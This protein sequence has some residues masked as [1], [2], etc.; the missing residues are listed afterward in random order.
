MI[1]AT[2]DLYAVL[3]DKDSA[4]YKILSED[5]LYFRPLSCYINEDSN[6]D[7]LLHRLFEE[8]TQISSEYVKFIHLEP[9]I[10]DKK[11]TISYYALVP[12]NI[13]PTNC[14]LIPIAET[15]YDSSMLRKIL[16]MV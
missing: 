11:L 1:K 14:H 12:Y 2:L 16:N 6:I 3:Y 8:H 5:P 13:I 15:Y 7:N 4:K 9:K 10:N